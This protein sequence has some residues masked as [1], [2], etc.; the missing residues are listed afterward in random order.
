MKTFETVVYEKQ[1]AV[2]RILINRPESLNAFNAQLRAELLEAFSEAEADSEARVV[3]LGSTGKAFSSGADLADGLGERASVEEQIMEEYA[4][5]LNKMAALDKPVIAA[6]PGVMAGIGAAFAMNC[7]LMV[8]ADNA[9]MLMAF[10]NIGLVPDGGASW[11]L[12]QK[13]GYQRAF[14]L[15]AEGGKLSAH[16][17]A[18]AGI[19]NKLV[20]AEQVLETAQ[21]WAEELSV[22]APIALRESKAVLRQATKLSYAETVALEAKKQNICLATDDAKEA[23]M[24]FME[25][26]QPVFKGK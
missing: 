9:Y 20:P 14:Q 5:I 26:R 22:R 6:V 12:L 24:A 2:I 21:H 10:S 8:L 4:P 11:Q 13:L 1:N 7:D 17:C 19:A 3:I 16:D 23:V 15:I 25:K 18:D